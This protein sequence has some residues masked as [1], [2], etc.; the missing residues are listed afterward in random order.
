MA[1][2]LTSGQHPVQSSDSNIHIHMHHDVN[3]NG[4]RENR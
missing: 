1:M 4:S 3:V 2:L